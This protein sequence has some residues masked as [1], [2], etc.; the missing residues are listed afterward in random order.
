MCC[1]KLQEHLTEKFGLY[2]SH[3]GHKCETEKP[4]DQT[5]KD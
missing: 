5:M 3:V 4:G 1:F 2:F